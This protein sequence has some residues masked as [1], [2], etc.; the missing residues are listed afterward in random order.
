MKLV[1]GEVLNYDKLIITT[2]STARIPKIENWGIKGCFALR[3]ADDGMEIRAYVQNYKC[4]QFVVAGGGLLGLEAAYA[5]TQLGMR[6]TVLEK[7]K[8]LLKRQ[9][10]E[11]SA[12][13]LHAYLSSF[14]INIVYQAEVKKVIGEEM[15]E[16]VRLKSGEKFYCDLLLV[17][18]GI[19]ASQNMNIDE[20][21]KIN[22]GILVDNHLKTSSTDIYAAGDIAELENSNGK[23]PGLWPV[24]VEQEGDARIRTPRFPIVCEIPTSP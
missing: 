24:A 14:D 15:I 2:G 19:V 12:D 1:T 8:H 17:A 18:A 23:L 6:V 3:T 21:M 4:K 9:L 16:G 22:K 5:F 13:I 20:N 11:K 7:S 10:D